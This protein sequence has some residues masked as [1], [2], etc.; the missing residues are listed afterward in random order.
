LTVTA[1]PPDV[2]DPD[3]DLPLAVASDFWDKEDLASVRI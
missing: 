3:A 1:V 2:G